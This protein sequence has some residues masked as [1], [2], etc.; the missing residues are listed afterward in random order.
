MKLW[1]DDKKIPMWV[2]WLAVIVVAVFGGICFGF[3]LLGY[4]LAVLLS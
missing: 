4:N 1:Y 2:E 3:I